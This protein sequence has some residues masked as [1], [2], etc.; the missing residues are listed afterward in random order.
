MRLFSTYTNFEKYRYG[1]SSDID[2]TSVYIERFVCVSNR[3]TSILCDLSRGVCDFTFQFK[4]FKKNVRSKP[5][6]CD[7][8]LHYWTGSNTCQVLPKNNEHW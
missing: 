4:L 8:I 6:N 3:L 7:R 1:K 2:I 5:F